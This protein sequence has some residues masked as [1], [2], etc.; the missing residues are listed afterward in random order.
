MTLTS[1]LCSSLSNKCFIHK[2]YFVYHSKIFCLTWTFIFITSCIISQDDPTTIFKLLVFA[3]K[4]IEFLI[5]Q[6]FHR[7]NLGRDFQTCFKRGLFKNIFWVVSMLGDEN[8]SPS[9]WEI[10]L[11]KDF[12]HTSIEKTHCKNRCNAFSSMFLDKGH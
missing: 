2:L 5:N 1:Y 3:L 7:R 10:S 4:I 11:A 8:I 6:I 9:L 12:L